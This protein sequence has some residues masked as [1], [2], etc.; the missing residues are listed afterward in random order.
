MCVGRVWAHEGSGIGPKRRAVHSA[1]TSTG[2]CQARWSERER[3][4]R[5]RPSVRAVARATTPPPS[6]IASRRP[7]SP[8]TTEWSRRRAR[9]TTRHPRRQPRHAPP[10]RQLR[11]SGGHLTSVLRGKGVRAGGGRSP[12]ARV[13]RGLPGTPPGGL[14]RVRAGAGAGGAD[15]RQRGQPGTQALPEPQRGR[16]RHPP[17]RSGSPA[18]RRDRLDQG[19]G[20]DRILCVGFVAQPGQSG[21]SAT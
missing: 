11:G 2:D 9:P 12:G 10:S 17:G 21:S 3:P 8:M 6:T 13:V 14:H 7:T 4:R 16:D 20:C 5:P 1:G 19:E 15:G 18:E